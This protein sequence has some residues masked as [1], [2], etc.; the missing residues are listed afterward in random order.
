ML[1][2]SMLC[3]L[4]TVSRL[5]GAW[6]TAVTTYTAVSVTTVWS[7]PPWQTQVNTLTNHRAKLAA[8]GRD[9]PLAS[10]KLGVT[11]MSLQK[12]SQ[13]CLYKNVLMVLHTKK[14]C[15][16]LFR[17]WHKLNLPLSDLY[18]YLLIER[19]PSDLRV[20]QQI[21]SMQDEVGVAERI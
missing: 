14:M 15:T 21:Q 5:S 9:V 1:N 16:S 19:T 20:L 17:S 18:S 11:T 10:D 7:A 13:N 2:A 12:C 3:C 4:D 6:L 8:F